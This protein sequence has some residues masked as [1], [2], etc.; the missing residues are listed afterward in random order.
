MN[1]VSLVK[2]II[3][4]LFKAEKSVDSIL[5]QHRQTIE[6]LNVRSSE[7]SE[8]SDDLEVEIAEMR[9]KLEKT[10]LERKRADAAAIAMS[11][12]FGIADE[13]TL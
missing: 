12:V 4:A 3:T 13:V 10:L 5:N 8:R 7:M 6:A 11:Q 1:I 9:L 2:K